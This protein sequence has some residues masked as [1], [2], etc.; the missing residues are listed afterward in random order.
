[1]SLSCSREAVDVREFRL[2]LIL[3]MNSDWYR[4]AERFAELVDQESGGRYRVRIFP[5]AQLAGNQRSELEML[6]TGVID[7][8]LESSI[9][10]SLIEPSMSVMSLPWLFDNYGTA[11]AVCDGEAGEQL[12]GL[13]PEKNIVGLAFGV[14]GFRQLTNSRG[15]VRTPD[16]LAAMK[17][18]VPGI[19]MYI[20]LFKLLGA[21]PSAMNFAE[22]FTALAQG[23]MDGQENPISVI[24]YSRLYEVQR[25]LT[26]WNYS[27][28]PI[29]LCANGDLWESL[30][31][32]DRSLIQD[33]ARKAMRYERNLVENGEAALLD[34]LAVKGMEIASL[35]KTET[36]AFRQMAKPAYDRLVKVTG[37]ELIE[38][39]QGSVEKMG[40]E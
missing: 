2:S 36:E 5:H 39:I 9:L 29:I 12:L 32:A 15:P 27:Y 17:L 10:L 13:L 4:G 23:T 18:R 20:D 11:N 3:G 30:P 16:D 31:P 22:V 26:C 33:C 8:A 21:D 37:Y 7:F 34:S 1:M 14:N 6:Q 35:T 40:G 24:Y 38:M 19:R 25:Y 28:D